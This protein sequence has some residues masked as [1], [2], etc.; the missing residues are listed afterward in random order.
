MPG[1]TYLRESLQ[2]WLG[3]I[4]ISAVHQH[5]QFEQKAQLFKPADSNQM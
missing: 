5:W 3:Q 2:N 1:Y 4:V